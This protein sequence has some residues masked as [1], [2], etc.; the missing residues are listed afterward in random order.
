MNISVH[1]FFSP[2]SPFQAFYPANK[3]VDVKYGDTLA[4]RCMFSGE[5][6]TSNTYI[7]WVQLLKSD[8]FFTVSFGE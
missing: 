6:R 4:A 3:D 5:G 1:V 7:G 8:Y 2:F